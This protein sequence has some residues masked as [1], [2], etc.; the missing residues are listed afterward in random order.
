ME[1]KWN[2]QIYSDLF[3][4]T[5]KEHEEF[6][7]ILSNALKEIKEQNNIRYIVLETWLV[8]DFFVRDAIGK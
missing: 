8:I 1:K 4:G 2:A 7:Y 5:A 6:N 3:L